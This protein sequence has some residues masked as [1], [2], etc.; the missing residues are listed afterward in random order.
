MISGIY[1]AYQRK[2]ILS[3]PAMLKDQ[4]PCSVFPQH[5]YFVAQFQLVQIIA[6]ELGGDM[7]K[8]I[9]EFLCCHADAF[10]SFWR[11]NPDKQSQMPASYLKDLT[12]KEVYNH[13]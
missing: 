10:N 8:A 1:D 6:E 11:N 12:K 7:E 13:R 3:A 4:E 9:D 5:D 2:I